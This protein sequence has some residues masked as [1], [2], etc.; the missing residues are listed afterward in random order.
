MVQLN[1]E[2]WGCGIYNDSHSRPEDC[3]GCPIKEGE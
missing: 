3:E 2:C 1:K